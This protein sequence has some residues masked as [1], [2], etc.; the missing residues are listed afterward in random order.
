MNFPCKINQLDSLFV[1]TNK[2]FLWIYKNKKIS[3]EKRE[4]NYINHTPYLQ[5]HDQKGMM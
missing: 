2:I 1:F 3:L 4:K 5:T